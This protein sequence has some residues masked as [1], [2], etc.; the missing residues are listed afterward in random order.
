MSFRSKAIDRERL[1]MLRSVL[2]RASGRLG[3]PRGTKEHEELAVRLLQLAD[4]IPE[5]ERLVEVLSR[6]KPSRYG[7]RAAPPSRAGTAEPRALLHVN[8]GRAEAG[9]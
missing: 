2:E 7:L 8:G 4:V 5:K 9:S 3:V 1:A 6:S